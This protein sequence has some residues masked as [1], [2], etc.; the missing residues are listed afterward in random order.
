MSRQLLIAV[1]IQ[2]FTL[3]LLVA[4]STSGQGLSDTKLS[5][6]IQNGTLVDI[7]NEIQTKTRFV[8]AYP[9]GIRK[10]KHPFSLSA[11]HESLRN[12]LVTIG[13]E[14]K[15]KF[16]SINYTITVAYDDRLMKPEIIE[17]TPEILVF[18]TVSGTVTGDDGLG[19]P[20][21][22]VLEKGTTNGSTTDAEGHY[23]INVQDEQAILV[24][25]FIGYKPTEIPVAGRTHIDVVLE[26]DIQAL[27]EVVVVGYGTQRK[28]AI[29][30]AIGNVDAEELTKTP[31]VTTSGMLVGRVQGITARR[32]DA[33]PGAATSIQ[34]R[35]MGQPMY[36]IDGI[37]SDAGQ[38]NNLG[39][40]DIESISVLKD[41]AAAI[42]GL[43]AANGVI[44][45]TTKKGK[46]GQKPTINLSGYYGLQNFTRFPH[47]ASAYQHLLAHVEASVNQ[48]STPPI[49]PEELQKWKEGKEPGYK[50]FDYYDFIMRPNV[51]Q[52]FFSGS[53]S[54][55]SETTRYYFSLSHLNQE[56]LIE[57]YNFN[58]TNFQSNTETSL[59][60]GLTI[61]SQISGRI[62]SRHQAGVPGL[63]D[64]FNPFLSIFTM[65]PTVHPYANDNPN[66]IND[67]RVNTNPATYK[68]DITGYTEEIWRAI[69]AN[70][71]A[72]YD[73]NFGLSAKATYSYNFANMDFDG[74][75]YTYDAYT[76]DEATD[77]YNRTGGNDNPWRERRR[78]NV[79]DRVA[80]L[81]LN[82]HKTLGDH[83]LS[84]TAGYERWDNRQHYQVVHTIPPNN[85][86]PIMSFADQD[87][88]IDELYEEAREG[89]LARANYSYKN[90]Y[91][92]E[93]L[94][95]YDGSFLFPKGDR[96][97]L[98]P[99]ISLGWR[100]TEEAFMEPYKGNVL[101]DVK[102]RASYSK[103]GNDRLY[104]GDPP[105]FVISPYSYYAGYDFITTAGGSAVLDGALVPGVDPRGLPITNFSWIDN[106]LKNI[107]I[108]LT[109]FNGKLFAQIDVFERKRE[110]LP[111]GRYDVAIPD[112]VGYSLPAENLES[113]AHR[114]IEGAVTYKGSFK[115]VTYTIGA[116]ATISRIK[117]LDRY[118]PRYGNAWDEYRTAQ[119]DRWADIF[120]G[121]KVIGQFQSQEE[122]DNYPINNDGQG[123]RSQL[124]GDLKFKDVNNDQ[125]I[126][127]LD[128]RPIGYAEGANPYVS[129][130]F[131]GSISYKGFTLNA[132]FAGAAMQTFNR[133]WELRFPFPN[134]GT[135]PDYLFK[136]RWHR[137]DPFDPNSEWIPGKYPSVRYDWGHANYRQ[138]GTADDFWAVNV[139]YIRLR[140]LEL[141][142][143]FPLETLKKMGMEAL[144]VYINGTNLFSLDNV[145][146][147]GIDPEI[148][149]NNALV[150]PQQRLFNFGFNVTL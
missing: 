142:Y 112:E 21:V 75:E 99:G 93:V 33:R 77:T 22:N 121:Y 38:F 111:A 105:P 4:E 56:A 114:G 130:G 109:L 18:A 84:A 138:Y 17:S 146:Q 106:T 19:L 78:R 143:Q 62:E 128:E 88:L 14:A 94:G 29:T 47:P 52:Y 107:G 67:Y 97:G 117:V 110:G 144:R 7:F 26:T 55:G 89:Y 90:T 43:R 12:I 69:K 45:V 11:S 8:F 66:Y 48:G 91:F 82:Y 3:P 96:F 81:Q 68:E 127:H 80:Q 24:F 102:I 115:D 135:S 92:A 87:I 72:T 28:E 120:W 41:G 70:F 86:I 95:R 133:Y 9:D 73:F 5:I 74:F 148:T 83:V 136:D 116:N 27:E 122:I 13:R 34:I 126:N 150:Y 101:S 64:Y 50:S 134:G 63:D 125:I 30:G 58:R 44:M 149:P 76:Y 37:P 103:I 35:N 79:I 85:Y 108:D 100:I 137:S 15:L 54:G 1:L 42:Y 123:N 60:K 145:K 113:D 61:G 147:Y 124:P 118:K 139:H 39:P 132:D 129:F 23:R 6:S 131:N 46:I 57:D 32:G 10:D 98:F 49:T 2:T 31:A 141:A 20:G 16:K 36:V 59:S 51:P 65:E 140:N 53:A 25:S 71:F 40:N 104:R 119:G